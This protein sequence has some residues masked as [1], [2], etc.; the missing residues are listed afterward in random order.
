MRV[1]III[2]RIE[3][4]GP[5][6]VIQALVNSF[7]KYQKLQIK[8][9][10]L[11]KTVDPSIKMIVPVERLNFRTFP[12]DDYD[13]IH[14]N[15][16]RPDLFAFVNRNKI[17]ADLLDDGAGAA[18]GAP[19]RAAPAGE[20]RAGHHR[21]PAWMPAGVAARLGR[22]GVQLLPWSASGPASRPSRCRRRRCTRCGTPLGG[23]ATGS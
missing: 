8:V 19:V 5:V 12:F 2:S 9:F 13:I 11:D 6:K 10:Y 14:T 18:G 1:A 7:S 23:P 16:I 20:C 15:G 4:L 17:D 21:Q 3:Q 22:V